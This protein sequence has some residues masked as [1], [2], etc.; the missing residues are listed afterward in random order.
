[1]KQISPTSSSNDKRGNHLMAVSRSCKTRDFAANKR[2]K[3]LKHAST[4]RNAKH[5][6]HRANS[7]VVTTATHCCQAYKL[8]QFA[9]VVKPYIYKPKMCYVVHG[10]HG[11]NARSS[12]RSHKTQ[13]YSCHFCTF[14]NPR[15]TQIYMQ[16]CTRLVGHETIIAIFD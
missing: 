14:N 9:C 1:M 12:S 11:I 10:P 13:I 5:R 8:L 7:H 2:G 6:N 4:I 16:S 15:S 3:L